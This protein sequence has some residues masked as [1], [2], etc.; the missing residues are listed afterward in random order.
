MNE[1]EKSDAIRFFFAAKIILIGLIV[2]QVLSTLHVYVSNIAF[3]HL[4][5]GVLNAGYLA[6][7]NAITLPITRTFAAAFAGGLFFTLTIGCFISLVSFFY[8]WIWYRFSAKKGWM[9]LPGLFVM[10]IV[11][12]LVNM[13]NILPM[14]STYFI[15][16][17]VAVGL[18]ASKWLPTEKSG[19]SIKN[20]GFYVFP[21]ILIVIVGFMKLDSKVFIDFRD[22]ILL[23]NPVGKTVNDFYYKYTLFPAEIFKPFEKKLIKTSY[24]ENIEN[25]RGRFRLEKILLQYDYL[26]QSAPPSD[27]VLTLS[28]NVLIMRDKTKAIVSVDQKEFFKAPYT[29]LKAFSDET[30]AYPFFRKITFVSLLVG[31]PICV[32]I[33]VF[34]IMQFGF[35]LFTS[36]RT[37][38]LLASMAC[39]LLGLIMMF[40]L[41]ANRYTKD[42][43]VTLAMLLNSDNSF[44][45]TAAIK[46][47]FKKKSD[48]TQY[49]IGEK[50]LKSTY[51]PE[52][53]W[54]AMALGARPSKTAEKY[55]LELMHDPS[56]NVRCKVYSG[57]AKTQDRSYIPA[58]IREL[59]NSDHLYAQ[60]YAYNA[61][62]ELGWTQTKPL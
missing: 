13:K 3:Y 58:L 18:A 39:L 20:A 1:K 57:L 21:F 19:L 37:A 35:L 17:P 8:V 33:L 59:N 30:D 41:Q 53:Y 40:S 26:P 14:A 32:Y 24:L 27:M 54:L 11:V 42:D 6:V 45:R 12:W 28:G 15:V 10:A 47:I 61:L 51:I 56:V 22:N 55:L 23:A 2:A 25:D 60:L 9:L 46:E 50:H 52:R 44:H 43:N 36:M 34:G 5:Q 38:S 48:I 49:P 4:I 7:P 31:L 62:K 16:I 29:Y